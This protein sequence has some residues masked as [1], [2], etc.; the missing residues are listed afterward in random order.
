MSYHQLTEYE[1][2][3]IYSLLKEGLNQKQ[4]AENIGR[5]PSTVS[6]ELNRNKGLRGYR[7]KQAQ[8]LSD[9]RRKH[10][11]KREKLSNQV[12]EWIEQLIRQDLSPQQTVDYLAIHKGVELH[13]ETVYQWIYADKAKGGDLY[14]HLRIASKPYR[15]RYGHYDR[16]GKLRNRVDIDERPNIVDRR[17]RIGDW[18]GDTIIGKGRKS[19]LLTMVERKTL[20]TVIVKLTGKQADLLAEAAIEALMPLKNR[21]KT[22]TLDNGLEFAEHERIAAALGAKVYFAHPYASWERG[23]NENTNGLI[24][25]YFPKGT[26]FNEVSDEE[27]REVMEKLN[28]RP[29]ETR[30]C[31]SPNELFTGLRKDLLAA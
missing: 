29:R 15:K 4:I 1:R 20:Y 25:Q 27:I 23:I 16:R 13:H 9:H 28:D 21:I 31:R 19:A 30:G 18:E 8:E 11:H 10:A 12:V 14:S 5:T 26:D 17:T 22:I 7:P 2:Y 24:R 3:Q 6:R